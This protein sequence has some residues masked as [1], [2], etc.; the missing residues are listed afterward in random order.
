MTVNLV[1]DDLGFLGV[2]IAA[3]G[4]TVFAT[5]SWLRRLPS[6]SMLSRST[7]ALLL[8]MGFVAVYVGMVAAAAGAVSLHNWAVLVCVW[9]GAVALLSLTDLITG[10]RFFGLA[11]L[12]VAGKVASVTIVIPVKFG[13]LL[14]DAS[15]GAA[16]AVVFLG[17]FFL[18]EECTLHRMR[19]WWDR[20]TSEPAELPANLPAA[21]TDVA[22]LPATSTDSG[23]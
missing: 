7:S 9:V 17:G 22:A 10:I 1:A 14:R 23:S 2:L 16:M 19:V 20:L 4:A 18:T 21:T 15:I 11:I 8:T 3:A 6:G 12:V 13:W 5:A